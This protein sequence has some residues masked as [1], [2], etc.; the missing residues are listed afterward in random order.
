MSPVHSSKTSGPSLGAAEVLDMMLGAAT[1]LRQLHSLDIVH[2]DVSLSTMAMVVSPRGQG[3]ALQVKM[4]GFGHAARL[5]RHGQSCTLQVD[6]A[7][8]A[9]VS[10]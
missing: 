6:S 9:Q 4:T 10:R 8:R 3:A 5:V 1:A 2:G 7:V